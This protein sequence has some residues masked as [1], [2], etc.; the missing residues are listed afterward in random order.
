MCF[1]R[2]RRLLIYTTLSSLSSDSTNF[3][4]NLEALGHNF[5][6]SYINLKPLTNPFLNF[7]KGV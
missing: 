1:E 3:I 5:R 2:N 6:N 4:D 7:R